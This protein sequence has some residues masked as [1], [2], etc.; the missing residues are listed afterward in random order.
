MWFKKLRKV[1]SQESVPSKNEY[2][3]GHEILALLFGSN[4]TDGDKNF[5][6]NVKGTRSMLEHLQYNKCHYINISSVFATLENFKEN[7]YSLTKHLTD[8]V[9]KS[10]EGR[11]LL[12]LTTLR[13]SQIYDAVGKARKSQA[14]LFYFAEKIKNQEA[15]TLFGDAHKKRSYI[16]VEIACKCILH[17]IDK[18]L[19]GEHNVVMKD[20]YSLWEVATTF[21]KWCNYDLARIAFDPDKAV[22]SYEI[23]ACSKDFRALLQ[24]E[25]NLPY[26]EKLFNNV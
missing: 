9:V 8:E 2:I 18:A 26:F 23:P 11:L 3:F 12:K 25:S 24:N 1:A 20:S 14:G 10:F 22:V 4:K 7:N 21:S 19:V 5:N 17:T 6:V 15:L 13:F 16:P